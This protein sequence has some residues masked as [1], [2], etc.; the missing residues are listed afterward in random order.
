MPLTIK[1]PNCMRALD[2]PDEAA[3]KLVRCP[4]CQEA[5]AL[6]S[7]SAISPST[8][9]VTAQ[10][11]PPASW[12][13]DGERRRREE[14]EA[15]ERR[16]REV[17]DYDRYR[18]EPMIIGSDAPGMPHRG[19]VILTLGI[20]SLCFF[21][22]FP[23]SWVLGG[24]AISMAN[25]DLMQIARRHMDPAGRGITQTGKT[26]ATIG[27]SFATIWFLFVCCINVSKVGH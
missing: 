20:L 4:G 19:A 25:T 13:Q 21:C 26:L 14:A 18:S 10:P 22:F 12:D 7:P 23:V 2:V 9:G 8:E 17:E 16:R 3:G 24:V 11:L 6:A 27:V 15:A 5:F 1:C